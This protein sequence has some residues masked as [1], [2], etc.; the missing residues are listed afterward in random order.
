MMHSVNLKQM[1][2]VAVDAAM[3][4]GKILIKYWGNISQISEKEYSGD[5]VTEADQKSEKKIKQIIRHRLPEHSILAEESGLDFSQESDFLWVVDPLDGTTNYTHQFPMVAI[6]IALLHQKKPLVAIVYNPITQE[7]FRAISGEGAF[8]NNHKMQ[9]SSTNQLKKSLLATGFAYDRVGTKDN[10]YR[11]FA[12]MTDKSQGVRRLGSAALDLAYV[13]CGRLDGFWER[14][15]KT[16]DVAAGILLVTEAG[17]RI[18]NYEGKPFLWESDRILAT[19]GHIHEE[20]SNELI[21]L[22]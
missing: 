5:L 10:N 20:L 13:A 19:N 8:L 21:I 22:K 9:V 16:W 6:S 1:F 14:G 18:S 15:L 3:E 7:M 17:G 11:E 2:V 12:T 4:A